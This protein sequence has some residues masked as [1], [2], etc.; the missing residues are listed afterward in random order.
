MLREYAQDIRSAGTALLEIISDVLD[1]S[2]IEKG[3]MEIENAVAG[4]REMYLK[5]GFSDYL[6]K[7]V[8]L[9][10]MSSVIHKHLNS[11]YKIL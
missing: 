2:K 3:K 5:C 6:S 10:T 8:D 11:D 7:P 4:A 9:E 1:F